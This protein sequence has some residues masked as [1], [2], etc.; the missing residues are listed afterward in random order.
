MELDINAAVECED[1]CC[2]TVTNI[3]INPAARTVAYLAIRENKPPH[4]EIL[5]PLGMIGYLAPGQIHLQCTED[6]LS[7]F[8]LFIEQDFVKMDAPDGP[9]TGYLM[10][11][12]V[13]PENPSMISILNKRMPEG[14]L[15]VRRGA[16]VQATDGEAGRVDEFLLDAANGQI[17]HLVM[18][19]GQEIG[20]KEVSIPL[21]AIDRMDE[22]NVY[23]S[24]DTAGLKR[25]SHIPIWRIFVTDW[26]GAHELAKVSIAA[27]VHQIGKIAKLVEKLASGN[28]QQRS[29]ARRKLVAIGRQA[30]PSLN[31]QLKQKSHQVRWEAAKALAQ[32][33]KPACVP[34]LLT[35]MEDEGFDIR[36]V[37]AEGMATLGMPAV[38]CLLKLL[39][40]KP[41]SARLRESAHQV[42]R[43]LVKDAPW[44]GMQPV[45]LE[46]EKFGTTAASLPHAA[47]L[48]LESLPAYSDNETSFNM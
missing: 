26:Q 37:A 29:Q 5:A 36:W 12:Y 7:R 1:S 10:L 2:G 31:W 3:I 47:K 18:R 27:S 35:A 45:L 4:T 32:I 41:D 8:P 9:M 20:L 42:I 43:S 40:E 6:E 11:P 14:E 13:L 33:K 15:A 39:Q 24:L 22:N 28:G 34:G 30:I 16:F 48:A 19:Q 38:R 44:H 23:L 17:T 25:L 21:D 46:L